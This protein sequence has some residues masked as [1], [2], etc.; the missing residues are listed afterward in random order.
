M[1]EIQKQYQLSPSTMSG[2]LSAL[3]TAFTDANTL[4]GSI[5]TLIRFAKRDQR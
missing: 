4:L 5:S 3:S 2:Y 1:M